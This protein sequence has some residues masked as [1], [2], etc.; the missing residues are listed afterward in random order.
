MNTEITDKV[1]N[2]ISE[3]TGLDPQTIHADMSLDSPEIGMSSLDI[4]TTLVRLE[5][6]YNIQFPDSP[7]EIKVMKNIVYLIETGLS[8]M[9]KRNE[10][11]SD[12][13]NNLFGKDE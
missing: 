12:A 5:E 11:V 10:K 6:I 2:I 3:I 7:L 13:Y 1:K 4:V 9:K 8:Q